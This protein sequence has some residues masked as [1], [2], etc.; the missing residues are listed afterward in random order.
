MNPQSRPRELVG[1]QRPRALLIEAFAE[2]TTSGALLC[3]SFGMGRSHL[4]RQVA[5][6]LAARRV[7]VCWVSGLRGVASPFAPLRP[8][9]LAAGELP[10]TTFDQ[11]R[12]L[13]GNDGDG[14][15]PSVVV[16]DDAHVIP[17]ELA[18]VLDHLASVGRSRMLLTART[19]CPLPT[20]LWAHAGTA[21]GIRIELPPL[22]RSD[23]AALCSEVL[24]APADAALIDEVARRSTG[25]PRLARDLLE[26]AR[27]RGAM[28]R[29]DDQWLLIGELDPDDALGGLVRDELAAVGRRGRDL[30]EAV[31]LARSLDA[32]AIGTSWDDAVAEDL[33]DQGWLRADVQPG[34]S[35]SVRLAEPLLGDLIIDTLGTLRRRRHVARLA[36][37]AGRPASGIPTAQAVLLRNEAGEVRPLEELR[38]AANCLVAEERITHALTL[39]RELWDRSATAADGDLLGR[40]LT[41]LNRSDEAEQVFAAA[42]DR[43]R[44]DRERAEL[45]LPRAENLWFASRSTDARAVCERTL[46]T[47]ADPRAKAAVTAELANL[48]ARDG[49]IAAANDVLGRP[50]STAL[51]SGTPAVIA[52]LARTLAGVWGGRPDASVAP[53]AR[54]SAAAEE[55]TDDALPPRLYELILLARA[56]ALCFAGRFG[57]ACAWLDELHWCAIELRTSFGIAATALIR[58]RL[59]VERGCITSS[60]P[61]TTRA[62]H[63]FEVA[64]LGRF[65]TLTDELNTFVEARHGDLHAAQQLLE[66]AEREDA[67]RPVGHVALGGRARAWIDHRLGDLE[68]A[69]A[70]QHA[71]AT[72]LIERGAL[73]DA[74]GVLTDAAVMGN[75]DEFAPTATSLVDAVDGPLLTSRLGTVIATAARDVASLEHHGS[76]LVGI[77]SHLD[78]A[79]A[80]ALAATIAGERADGRAAR[81]DLARSI[82][83]EARAEGV[84]SIVLERLRPSIEQ[85]TDREHL[86][87]RLAAEGL[88]SRDIAT[89]LT[90]S[91]R[92]VDN[93]LGR[94][95]RKLHVN[96]RVELA[97]VLMSS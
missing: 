88:S 47:L 45:T 48:C 96:G 57:E 75:A 49:D 61:W 62:T 69:T 22:D 28:Q 59:E 90:I 26:W 64:G 67:V 4:A 50:G 84:R 30:I 86:V 29:K 52:G 35:A 42:H 11:A 95:Y 10:P 56:D 12:D 43:A 58:A 5:N 31:A 36:E 46:A 85:L 60:R 71:T 14:A 41:Q 19:G 2:R 13:L 78:A 82:A 87:A 40:V 27:V 39:S 8:I 7:K 77:G 37:H 54:A 73:T 79:N 20:E 68:Q 66:A 63:A 21:P 15:P 93:L 53:G 51:T 89:K 9:A 80:Y 83:A 76:V 38:A 65:T 25:R 55:P 18:E 16:V 94:V 17:A 34:G 3:G 74:V 44:S 91:V 72:S 81:L 6:D 23:V 1:R 33:E 24:G 70:R 32:D 92:T 97:E